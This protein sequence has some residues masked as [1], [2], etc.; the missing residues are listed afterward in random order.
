MNKILLLGLSLA[1]S[2]S[3][4]AEEPV[5]PAPAVAYTYGMHL[6]I[7]K[8][9][10]MTSAADTCGPAPAEMTYRDSQGDVHVLQYRLYGT[11]CSDS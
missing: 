6:D 5:T 2:L 3:A 7:A 10:R 9:I 11:G 8:V 4:Y 1:A